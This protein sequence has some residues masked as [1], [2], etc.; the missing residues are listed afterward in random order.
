MTTAV[1]AAQERGD[2]PDDQGC[3]EALAQRDD[4]R[5]QHLVRGP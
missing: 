3:L 5:R 1:L 4:E 2:D